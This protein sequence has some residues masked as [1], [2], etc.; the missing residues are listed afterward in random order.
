VASDG[1]PEHAEG[2][3]AFR[4]ARHEE[5]VVYAAA[6]A[7]YVLLGVALQTLVLNWI[8]G[9]LYFVAFVW[10][11]SSLLERRRRHR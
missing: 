5:P 1:G 2:A 3:E 6:A 7:S 11:S 10:A 9:P 8:V 4:W